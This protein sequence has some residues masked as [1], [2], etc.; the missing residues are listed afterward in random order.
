MTTTPTSE[1]PAP[2]LR[3]ATPA[4]VSTLG[5]VLRIFVLLVISSGVSILAARNLNLGVVPGGIMGAAIFGVSFFAMLKLQGAPREMGFTFGLKFLSVTAY[6]ILNITLVFWLASDFGYSKESALA[7]I[8]GWSIVMTLTTLL[9][10]SITDALGL[11]RTLVLGVSLCVMTRLVMVLTTSQSLALTFGLFPLAIGE[12]LCTPVLIAALRRYSTASQR[13]VAFSLFY[14]I[15]NFGFMVAYFIFDGVRESIQT[16]GRITLPLATSELG[17][18]RTLLLVSMGIELLMLPLILLLRHGA[19]MTENGLQTKPEIRKYP[20][21]GFWN[22]LRFT[23]RDAAVDAVNLFAGLIQS[24]GFYRLLVFLLM[25]GFL[26]VVFNVMDYILPPFVLQALGPD[27]RVGR[28][29]AINGILILVLAPAIGILTRHYSAYSMV[30]LGGFITTLSFLFLILPPGM[31][32]GM[33]GNWV[34]DAI[35]HGYMELKGS[36]HPYYVMIA[37]WQILFSIGEAFYSPRVYEY[38]SSIAPQGQEASYASLSYV[39]LLIG[40]LITGAAFGGLLARYCPDHGPR[41]PSTMWLIIGL[42]VLIAPVG[43]LVL[44]RF[45]RMKE[46]GRES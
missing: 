20:D 1:D 7:L 39:P 33:A 15:M 21:A 13:S 8:A 10:G 30:I 11:R 38:A 2:I 27:A 45:I 46:A 4:P 26:K 31:F 32:E 16:H 3:L 23:V 37:F 12:A 44:R 41:D 34:G 14:A 19:E 42:M 43:L 29:N 36:V 25:I 22:S 6:K 35:G 9:A 24:A 17:E 18:F 40:K 28:F 5:W